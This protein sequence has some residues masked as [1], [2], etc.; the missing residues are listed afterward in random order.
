[1]VM[2]KEIIIIIIIIIIKYK[3][4]VLR[5]KLPTHQA[6]QTKQAHSM[7]K[8]DCSLMA[9][10][11][12]NFI[13]CLMLSWSNTDHNLSE[14]KAFSLPKK[15]LREVLHLSYVMIR[16]MV[17]AFLID[18]ILT[19]CCR[20]WGVNNCTTVRNAILKQIDKWKS[21]ENCKNGGEKCLYRVIFSYHYFPSHSDHR[22]SFVH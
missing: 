19:L 18:V 5:R 1:M 10:G 9:F 7:A 14:K 2:I 16:V 13:C 6:Y 4:E 11:A 15:M 21:D 17:F 20:T 12:N 22:L 3:N 8:G